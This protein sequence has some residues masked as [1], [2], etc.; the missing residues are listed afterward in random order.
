M[1]FRGVLQHLPTVAAACLLF[2]QSLAPAQ[3]SPAATATGESFVALVKDRQP[4]GGSTIR[5][6]VRAFNAEYK[7]RA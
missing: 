2:A 1:S 4:A 5:R 6:A 3:A 7:Q